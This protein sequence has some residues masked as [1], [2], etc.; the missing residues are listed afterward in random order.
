[1]GAVVSFVEDVVGGIV[2]AVGDVA[3]AV[4]DTAGK[5]LDA[6]A[7]NPLLIVAA[8]AAPYAL[9]ALAAEA[10][11]IG[12]LEVAG[13][14]EAVST[15]TAV[16]QATETATAVASAET[17]T[18]STLIEGGATV[19]EA[20]Q[21]ATLASQGASVADAVTTASGGSVT[22]SSFTEAASTAFDTA[23]NAVSSLSQGAS[24]ILNTVG[25]TLLPDAD[26]LVQQ[27]AGKVAINTATNGGDFGKSLTDSLISVGTGF[28]G[29]EV[30][31][32]TGSKLIG[33]AAASTLNTAAH[34]QD[35]NGTSLGT[36]LLGSAVSNEVSDATGSNLAGQ[37]AGSVTKDVIN[38]KDPLTGLLKVG[39][40]QLGN[41]ATGQINDFVDKNALSGQT[42]GTD[43]ATS[44]E[45]NNQTVTA[46]GGN[47]DVKDIVDSISSA[48]DTKSDDVK[49]GLN[50]VSNTP[51][52]GA[53][54]KTDGVSDHTVDNTIANSTDVGGEQK[55][56]INITGPAT[57]GGLTSTAKS[58]IDGTAD[59]NQTGVTP[60]GGL[61]TVTQDLNTIGTTAP[62]TATTDKTDTTKD[63]TLPV[64]VTS[65]LGGSLINKAIKNVAGTTTR[66]VINNA[67]TGNKAPVTKSVPKTLS[68]SALT[69][70][71]QT[72][73]PKKVNVA[74]L[75]PV[76]KSAPAKVDVSKLTPI[77]NIAGLTSILK[78]PG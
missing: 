27:L 20:A 35:I 77:T 57:T 30:A 7:E 13:T 67:I 59:T 18:A 32:E 44:G 75:T 58:L 56:D 16:L 38:N 3:E 65:G 33:Q 73:A 52:S 12:G 45:S 23:S 29:S 64:S 61:N 11:V 72:P 34:G 28:V 68:G 39:A 17:V 50:V 2:D 62:T 47:T 48:N 37:A 43:S 66:K 19:T 55:N 41:V 51:A 70:L 9:G 71:K 24:N 60:T 15:G 54:V 10:G 26:P 1:M 69:A 25:Q 49:G 78:K 5:V 14:A 8:V 40:N 21:G 46:F 76:N 31:S 53:D 63:T 6:V 74:N 22:A 42:T 36:S 4:V